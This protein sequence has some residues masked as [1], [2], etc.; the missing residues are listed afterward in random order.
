MLLNI[1]VFLKSSPSS[2][3][4]IIKRLNTSHGQQEI[5]WLH[6]TEK[7]MIQTGSSMTVLYENMSSLL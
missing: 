3:L 6:N 1:F 4:H 7:N 5:L 2:L